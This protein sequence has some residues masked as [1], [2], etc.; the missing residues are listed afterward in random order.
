MADD[1]VY[2]A[3]G[4]LLVLSRGEY[5]DYGYTGVFVTLEALSRS[6]LQELRDEVVAQYNAEEAATEAAYEAWDK[7]R[8]ESPPGTDVGKGPSSWYSGDKR[9]MFIAAMIRKGWLLS[10]T[11]TEL[12]IGSYGDLDLAL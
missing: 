12:H 8:R 2:L 7:L 6:A 1:D 9:E 3:A 11:Y 5:S 10:V 4:Q